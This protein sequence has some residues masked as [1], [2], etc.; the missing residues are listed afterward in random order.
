MEGTSNVRAGFIYKD[1][2]S[3]IFKDFVLKCVKSK[4][5][6]CAPLRT[7]HPSGFHEWGVLASVDSIAIETGSKDLWR[8]V[9][10][11]I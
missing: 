1:I 5:V 2:T 6:K 3:H 9:C 7:E 8:Q 4:D 11:I 10:A